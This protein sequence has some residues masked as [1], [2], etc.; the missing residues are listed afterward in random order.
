MQT[1]LSGD[2][3]YQKRAIRQVSDNIQN[4]QRSTRDPFAQAS[5]NQAKLNATMGFIKAAEN[6]NL[7]EMRRHALRYP[8][9]QELVNHTNPLVYTSPEFWLLKDHA[10]H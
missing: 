6:S 1:I 7:N 5:D 2:F 10:L 9:I 3:C 4:Q 8:G